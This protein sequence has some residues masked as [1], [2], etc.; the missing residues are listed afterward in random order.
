MRT[1]FI[2][3][4]IAMTESDRLPRPPYYAVVFTSTRTVVDPEGY[5]RMAERMVELAKQQ[6]G[7]L[8]IES[9]RG[10][11]GVGITVSYWES[12]ESI[13]RWYEHAEHREAQALGRDRWYAAFQLRVCRVERAYAFAR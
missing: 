5:E 3:G 11:D 7:Y 13:R 12:E 8:G 6:P 9:A 10:P 1:F 2:K 4:R